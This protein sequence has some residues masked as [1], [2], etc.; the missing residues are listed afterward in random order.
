M[1]RTLVATPLVVI[2]GERGVVNTGDL[3]LYQLPGLLL[4]LLGDHRPSILGL[5]WPDLAADLGTVRL[6]PL[7]GLHVLGLE[8]AV[9]A[10][11][12]EGVPHPACAATAERLEALRILSRDLF[13]GEQHALLHL[14][15]PPGPQAVE[16]F[17]VEAPD[18]T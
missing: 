2:D 4:S 17:G 3:P 10:C 13:A 14:E 15:A 12:G 11:R 1:F 16:A 8:D 5:T 9:I 6:R 18:A 7:P